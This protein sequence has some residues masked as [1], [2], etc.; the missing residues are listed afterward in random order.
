V[1][2]GWKIVSDKMTNLVL[3]LALIYL[4]Y[5]QTHYKMDVKF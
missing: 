5:V 3:S 2:N 4:K 1:I